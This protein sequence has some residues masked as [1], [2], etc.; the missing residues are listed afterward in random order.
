V[1]GDGR[2]GGGLTETMRRQGK[3]PSAGGG[4]WMG[5]LVAVCGGRGSGGGKGRRPE[6]GG[7]FGEKVA[8]CEGR[9]AGVFMRRV[10]RECILTWGQEARH[11]K[12]AALM[13]WENC[14]V[15]R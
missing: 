12:R 8:V 2:V 10:L 11:I 1:G 6:V 7:G 13:I 14:E 5:E 9:G 4:R 3:G 15:Q